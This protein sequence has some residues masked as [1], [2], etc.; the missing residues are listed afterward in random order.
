MRVI[1]TGGGTL[2]PVTPLLA[3]AE[4]LVGDFLWI[5]TRSGP[6]RA[7]VEA[8]GLSFVAIPS[9]KLRRY[10]WW[11]LDIV[12]TI[13]KVLAGFFSAFAILRRFHPNLVVTAGGYVGVPV[14]LAAWILRIPS[15]VIQ[16][17]LRLGLSN[18]LA[19]PFA[20]RIVTTF[21]ASLRH[22]PKGKT[23]HAG[24]PVRK[25]IRDLETARDR[26][27]REA[28]K[29]YG[30]DSKLQTL[31]VVGGGTGALRLNELVAQAAQEITEEMQIIHL[32]GPGKTV[33]LQKDRYYPLEFET[34][35]VYAYAAAD[36]ILARAG[37]GT[38]T[39]VAAVGLPTIFVPLPGTDQES[40]ARVFVDAGAALTVDQDHTSPKEIA[41]TVLGLLKDRARREN[42]VQKI[43]SV[44]PRGATERIVEEMMRLENRK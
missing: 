26:V 30:L 25:A 34:E 15:L 2:G 6:E 41:A 36:I 43:R 22:F 42:M 28:T 33:A 7:V 20:K 3:L 40:N 19:A 38:I 27:R 4:D 31:L 24:A 29:R 13:L 14:I 5:G 1:F 39:E 16:L 37:M 44:L 9:G 12:L 10:Y 18:I 35:M 11:N 21:G 8:S 17:D 23:L 32:T